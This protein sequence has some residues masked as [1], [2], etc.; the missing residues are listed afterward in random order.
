MLIRQVLSDSLIC[1]TSAFSTLSWLRV[2]AVREKKS[3]VAKLTMLGMSPR[4]L[5]LFFHA[6]AWDAIYRDLRA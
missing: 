5:A 4:D 2:L 3:I 6:L 1:R